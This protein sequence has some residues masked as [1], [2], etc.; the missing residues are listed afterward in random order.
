MKA[1]F[2]T[3]TADIIRFVTLSMAL[4]ATAVALA[5][6]KIEEFYDKDYGYSFHYPAGWQLH[7]LPEGEANRDIRALLQGPNGSSFTAIGEKSGT[8]NAETD[9]PATEEVKARVEALM[10]QTI[11][12]VYKTIAENIKALVM[13]VGERRDLSNGIAIK[14]YISTLHKMPAGK[15]IIVA[16]IHSYP[17]RKDYA[18]SFIM[19]AFWEGTPAKEQ[20]V[21]TAVFNSFRLLGERPATA[22]SAQGE[23]PE[24]KK[25]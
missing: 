15:P 12:Q 2:R 18:V 1:H 14:F 19:S 25:D 21:L 6:P 17:F 8:K 23:I 9:N 20:E 11:A 3:A 24:P 5:Q 7:N 16:G 22:E 4:L 10:S 13:T